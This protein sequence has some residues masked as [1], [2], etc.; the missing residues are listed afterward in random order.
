MKVV[1]AGK[2]LKIGETQEFGA[3]KTRKR[4]VRMDISSGGIASVV[5]IILMHD[6]VDKGDQIKIGEEIEATGSL[7][8]RLY[9]GSDNVEKCFME[10]Q[11]FKLAKIGRVVL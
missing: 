11:V 9:T 7:M 2:V 3:N 1:L 8:G 5:E 6:N 10:I 4:V